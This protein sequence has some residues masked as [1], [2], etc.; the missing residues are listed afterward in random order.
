LIQ[1]ARV[2]NYFSAPR[3]A[4][5]TTGHIARLGGQNFIGNTRDSAP[6]LFLAELCQ[7][8]IDFNDSFTVVTIKY[9]HTNV[10]L[11]VPHHLN[12]VAALLCKMHSVHPAR[13]AA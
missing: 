11:N 13:M 4:A 2:D 10:E 3:T 9:L 5:T 6:F 1:G 12:Y 7:S 8:Q